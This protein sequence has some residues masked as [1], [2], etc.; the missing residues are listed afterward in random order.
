MLRCSTLW[1]EEAPSLLMS[2]QNKES[3][4][5]V[6]QSAPGRRVEKGQLAFGRQN[7]VP[8]F[9]PDYSV[10]L[11]NANGN[12]MRNGIRVGFNRSK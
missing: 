9:W 2:E 11:L 3:D 8:L 5:H 12:K 6:Q 4:M 7:R 1:G 10:R